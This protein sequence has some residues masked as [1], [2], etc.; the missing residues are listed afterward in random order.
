MVPVADDAD[1]AEDYTPYIPS[2]PSS[3]SYNSYDYGL[4]NV[5]N[6]PTYDNVAYGSNA[7]DSGSFYGQNFGEGPISSYG[8][9]EGSRTRPASDANAYEMWQADFWRHWDGK[10]NSEDSTD[11]K[12]IGMP[13]NNMEDY[14][15]GRT[16]GLLNQF[17]NNQ[18]AGY[19]GPWASAV[20]TSADVTGLTAVVGAN[21]WDKSF[22]L[23]QTG[24]ATDARV[25]SGDSKADAAKLKCHVCKVDFQLLWNGS[26]FIVAAK[27][28][29]ATTYAT[30][31]LAIATCTGASTSCPY[32]SGTCFVEE[33]KQFGHV[34]SFERG[35]K[36]A[37]ACY[38]QKY[39]NFLV[40][41][42]RQCWPELNTD[43]IDEIARRP[44]DIKADEQYYTKHTNSF[45]DS[46]TDFSDTAASAVD[47]LGLREGLYVDPDYVLDASSNLNYNSLNIIHGV[48]GK[49]ENGMKETSRCTQC[50]SNADDCNNGW[51]PTTEAA[52]GS[53]HHDSAPSGK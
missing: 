33:R 37:K 36:Q 27:G 38:M 47:T 17:A 8:Y 25:F 16:A 32:S 20:R 22:E 14:K 13:H 5:L 41:A 40:K 30:N 2:A 31:A 51:S 35:C 42:G 6:Y 10:Q 44:Y 46:F 28:N 21:T 4:S 7:G 24:T 19:Q 9:T 11:L 26:A 49:Y 53:H 43:M 29:P 48:V 18:H 52:W 34:I 3:N 12:D 45:D 50:C 23:G 15:Q 39:Q 1:R